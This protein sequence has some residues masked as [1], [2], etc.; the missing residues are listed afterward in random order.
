MVEEALAVVRCDYRVC[1]GY[2]AQHTT[3][4]YHF[5]PITYG[6]LLAARD[7]YMKCR[8]TDRLND[9]PS[10]HNTSDRIKS[11]RAITTMTFT[12]RPT[13][14]DSLPMRNRPI[15]LLVDDGLAR[16]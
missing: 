15:V 5:S 2:S 16:V 11:T 3:Y 1:L 14:P 10:T 4:A 9:D 6:Y 8:Q 12:T 13:G 7:N